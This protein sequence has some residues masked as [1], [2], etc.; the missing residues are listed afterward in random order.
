MSG[1]KRTSK[2]VQLMEPTAL[3]AL[4]ITSRLRGSAAETRPARRQPRPT[5]R[6]RGC[7]TPGLPWLRADIC[8]PLSG[9]GQAT[10]GRRQLPG[11]N[12]GSP[13][14]PCTA[15]PPVPSSEAMVSASSFTLARPLALPP[16]SSLPASG[17]GG[18][19]G[20][21]SEEG[22]SPFSSEVGFSILLAFCCINCR[23][24]SFMKR[25]YLEHST[26]WEDGIREP[27]WPGSLPL[28]AGTRGRP[29]TPGL[30]QHADTSHPINSIRQ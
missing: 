14:P 21:G 1:L 19:S 7:A 4:R 17:P 2:A 5:T 8:R 18:S 30:C 27:R 28:A 15:A 29:Q 20:L 24:A 16:S 3:H 25:R 23:A 26:R 9:L 10:A 22:G 11:Q 13:L 6:G 12:R